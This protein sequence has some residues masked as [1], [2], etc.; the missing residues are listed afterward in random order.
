MIE[1]EGTGFR[2]PSPR[3][4]DAGIKLVALG[5]PLPVVLDIAETMQRET[6]IIAGLFVDPIRDQLVPDGVI[7]PAE[8]LPAMATS[9]DALRPLAFSAT[10][11]F[12]AE[13]MTHALT[14]VFGSA[15]GNTVALEHGDEAAA[16]AAPTEKKAS[17]ARRKS[18]P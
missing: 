17:R 8:D 7:P 1:R 10:E 3:I 18:K 5:I 15:V 13:A 6:A 2:V 14:Q 16:R 4:I 11:A 9:I 12:L